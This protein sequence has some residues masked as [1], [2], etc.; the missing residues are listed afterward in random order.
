[1]KSVSPL[2]SESNAHRPA[3]MWARWRRIARERLM[4]DGL[5]HL[6]IRWRFRAVVIAFGLPFLG[7]I[8]WNATQQATIEKAHVSEQTLS[9]ANLFSS[10]LDDHVEQMDRIL[11]TAAHSIG[12]A[13]GN[14]AAV[15]ALVQSMRS[16]VPTSV[17]NI[18]VWSLTGQNIASLD[19][20]AI[21][22]SFNATTRR[23]FREAIERRDLAIEAPIVS[24]GNGEAIAQF[25]RPVFGSDGRMV[26]VIT[27]STRLKE[28]IGQLDPSHRLAPD[29][30]VSVVDRSG[31]II[32]RSIDPAMWIGTQV[33]QLDR[34]HDAFA[35]GSGVRDAS[36]IDGQKLLLGYSLA[37]K[38][39]W[40]V[41][42]GELVETATAPVSERLLKNLG[43]G[44][45]ILVLVMLLAGRV[46]SWTIRPLL[47]LAADTER[48]GAGDLAHRSDVVTGA[49]I[50]TLAANFNRMAA[51]LQAREIEL[52]DSQRQMREIADHMPAQITYVDSEERY[53][54]VNS[55][56]GRMATL[57]A[58]EMI[59]KTVREIRGDELYEKVAQQIRR[60]LSGEATAAE[61][62]G[63]VD[64]GEFHLHTEYVPDRDGAGDVR[65][66][67]A[68]THDVTERKAAE[69]QLA[70]SEKRL[71]TI[72]D[73]L[74]AMICYIDA[75]RRFRFANRAFEKWF[76]RPL[77]EI[78]GRPFEE[79]LPPD[80]VAQLEVQFARGMS[81]ERGEYELEVP[82]L[83]QPSL[84]LRGSFIPDIDEATGAIRGVYGMQFNMTAAKEAEQ[85]LTRL[86][87]FDTLT[88]LPNRNQFNE[89]LTC[90][91][92]SKRE[93]RGPL[94]LMF[95]DIDHFK[96]VNDR[97]G[98]AGGD[99]LLKEFAQRLAQA[100]RP[101]DS[102]A[103]L[104]GDEFVILLE[105]LHS[106]EE[107]QFIARKIIAAVQ[108]PFT[109]GES[110]VHVTSSIGIAMRGSQ[111]ETPS[112][113]MMRADEAL[114][115]AKRS[116]RNTFRMA[117]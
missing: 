102:V 33:A 58:N 101:T 80:L 25:A 95:L 13:I 106:D 44:I 68:F 89:K 24:R 81:G 23:C 26:A 60:T 116:G 57:S 112:M 61:I 28:L 19:R 115:A 30:L 29:T 109:I 8:V 22:R 59:G 40:I 38:V 37:S 73:N 55:Y 87:Q 21:V 92:T 91:L 3:G 75:T 99:T 49:E 77:A 104:A 67:Y 103:R 27:M 36:G 100:V 43:I 64:G 114:Y 15:S 47:R 97:Y 96:Q 9:L 5:E 20:S 93:V 35:K 70:E 32:A 41:Y 105:G 107:P 53:R 2:D 48:L 12:P 16:S 94:A 54:F 39:N 71:V 69:L 52:R 84:W 117:S 6:N 110:L 1:M 51:A 63:V 79:F 31:T 90:A 108:K 18:A 83:G 14:T 7:Y 34:V 82:V 62:T 113:L 45:A 74:P 17:N 66:F 10:R 11:A 78:I 50:A 46:A 111:H 4:T 72:T 85:R 42:A 76:K 56:R 65:G 86:A 88:G 98:H